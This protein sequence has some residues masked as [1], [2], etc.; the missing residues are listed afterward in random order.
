MASPASTRPVPTWLDT[1]IFLA[2]MSGPPKF[3]GRELT[4]SLAGEIDS[5]VLIQIV[6]WVCGGLWVLAR[7]YPA[8]L[9]HRTIPEVSH[10][11]V[12]AGLLIVA[13]SLSLWESPGILLTAFVLGQFAVMSSFTWVFVE[14][15]GTEAFLRHLFLGVNILLLAIALAVFVAPDLVLMGGLRLRGDYIAPTGALATMAL[16]FCLSNVPRLPATLFWT[17]VS[18]FGVLLAASQTRTA[19]VALFAYLAVGYVHGRGLR[20]RKLVP[21]L[22]AACLMLFF[23]DTLSSAT[24]YMVRER[25]SVE[26]MSDRLPLW[27]YLAERVVQDAPLTGLGYYA[28]SR[29]LAP[30]YNPLLGNAHSVVFE[31][32]VGGGFIALTLYVLLCI[33]LVWHVGWLLHTSTDLAP[34]VALAGLL[35]VTLLQAL[36]ASD[37]LNPGP[38]GFT[39]WSLTS[40][41][42]ALQRDTRGGTRHGAQTKPIPKVRR[43]AV[44]GTVMAR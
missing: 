26:S 19:Y 28:A 41:V 22:A 38:V 1:L 35:A 42:Q 33:S 29:V 11:Q 32:L 25:E 8:L 40:L 20:V 34:A 24:R 10:L 13:L 18:F 7:L 36:T 31:I 6:V 37:G 17:A 30:R 27:N 9:K 12:L 23:L 39:F 16:V 15:F 4:A 21:V 3:R 14:R 5:V 43:G 2:L 44:P